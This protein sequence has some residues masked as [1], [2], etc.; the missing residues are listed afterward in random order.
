MF[1]IFAQIFCVLWRED[2]YIDKKKTTN[3]DKGIVIGAFSYI[4]V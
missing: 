2:V 3:T 4:H 1:S